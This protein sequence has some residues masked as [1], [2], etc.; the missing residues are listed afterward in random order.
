MSVRRASVG[1]APWCFVAPFAVLF[2]LFTLIP[3]VQSVPLSLSHTFGPSAS[4]PVGLEKFASALDDPRFWVA[5]R[6]TFLFAAGSVFIQL[7]VSLALALLLNRRRLVG[8]GVF[9]LLFFSPQLVGLVFAGVLASVI[10]QKQRGL[11][12]MALAA[13]VEPWHDLVAG[14]RL[15]AWIPSPTEMLALPWLETLALPALILTALWMYAGFNMIYFL[16]ALQ[17]VSRDQLESAMLDGAGPIRR[18]WHVTLP[19]IQPVAVFVVLLSIIGSFQLFELP[20]VMLPEGV[21]LQD[22][23]LTIVTY[24]FKSGFEAGDLGYAAAIGWMLA[25]IL[26]GF[27]IAQRL[28]SREGA[29]R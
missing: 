19:A 20:Y 9:R 1:L 8:R 25:I 23:G 28:V 24:L 26:A 17:N 21:G 13:F 3:L 2:V 15:E 5:L 27:A 29:L 6:N 11:V 7:P 14:G 12:N 18:F 10:F 16:A 22:R 4:L